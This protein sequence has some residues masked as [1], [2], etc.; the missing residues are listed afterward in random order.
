LVSALTNPKG[1]TRIM[2]MTVPRQ[3]GDTG[4]PLLDG[5]GNV[6][7]L[8]VAVSPA[9]GSGDTN[10]TL[11]TVVRPELLQ[12]FLRIN[13]VRYDTAA[14]PAAAAAAPAVPPFAIDIVCE[15]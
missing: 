8:V 9:E 12:R 6:A 5:D 2:Q 15:R 4:S 3:R 11:R 1:D 10:A 13:G 7:G 14:A